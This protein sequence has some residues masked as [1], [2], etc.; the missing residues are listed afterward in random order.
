[1]IGEA[2]R[3]YRRRVSVGVAAPRGRRRED[4]RRDNLASEVARRRAA[5]Y[6]GE[7]ATYF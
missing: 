7:V 1:V 2:G 5:R 4:G 6:L 3:R